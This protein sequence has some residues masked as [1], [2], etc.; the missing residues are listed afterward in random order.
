MELREQSQP[1]ENAAADLTLNEEAMMAPE[2]IEENVEVETA[3]EATP[4]HCRAMTKD[5]I[6]ATLEAISEKDGAD[7]SREEVSSLR[8]HFHAIRKSELAAEKQAFVDNGNDE[9]AFT[10]APDPLEERFHQLTETIK[11]KKALY[12]A[13][14]EA[15]RK[16]NLDKK[17]AIIDELGKMAEDTDNVNKLFPRFRELTQ[18]FK[19]V[20]EVPPTDTTDLYRNYSAAVERFYDQL[21][22]N[23]DLRDYDFK[24]NLEQKQLLIAEAEKLAAEEDVITAFRRLQELHDKWREIGPVA[25]EIREE[26]WNKFKD[27]SATVNKRYQ[28]FFEERKAR[29]RENEEKKT[30]ICERVEALDFDNVKSYA[31][32]DQ[33]TKEILAA[34]EDWKKLGFASKK[35]NNS[36]FARFRETCDTFFAKKAEYFKT[37]RDTHAANLEKKTSLCERAEE[38]KESTDWKKTADKLVELQKEWKTIGPVEK[39][40]S[41]AV[42][43]RFQTACDYFFDRR[44]KATSGARKAEQSNLRQKQEIINELK[45]ISDETSRDEAIKTVKELMAK[46]QQIGHVPFKDKDKIYDAYR[47]AVN[48]LYNRFDMKESKAAMA[49]FADTIN[50]ISGDEN[51]LYRERERLVRVFEQKRNE[52]K[53]YENNLG[54]FSV[55]SKSGN[56]LL[57]DMERKMQRIKDDIATLEEK[58]KMIDS[59]L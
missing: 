33:L 20:G 18:E 55:K 3:G 4:D 28:T 40:H 48:D 43:Q 49:N 36:L 37:M 38:L 8:Q 41:D 10:P 13:A 54:F 58:I 32:W 56:S 19:T 53:T 44:K 50:E 1:A 35:V 5:D 21:K 52:L 14:V 22:I 7:I 57:K 42:W 47:A 45:A 24:K 51:K 11:E 59:K 29:E 46:W 17:L 25:K 26:I 16:A 31:A 6:I 2:T 9:A 15:E 27:A 34:Q 30:A 39:K 23:K 12:V